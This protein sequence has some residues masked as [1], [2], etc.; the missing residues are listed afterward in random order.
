MRYD[1]ELILTIC[2]V[3]MG[4]EGIEEVKEKVGMFRTPR[5]HMMPFLLFT[6]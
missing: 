4:V 2:G 6:V 3:D 5:S 1:L